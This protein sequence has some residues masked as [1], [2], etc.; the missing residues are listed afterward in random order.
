LRYEVYPRAGELITVGVFYKYFKNPIELYFNQ[1]GAGSSSTFN[2]INADKAR[3]YGAEFELR[4]KLDF[5]E[6]LQNFTLQTNVSYIFNRVERD[7]FQLKRPMQGQS[8]Y[9]FNASLQY[10]IPEIGLN[11]T[12]LYNQIGDRILY[13]GGNDY[14]PVWEATR[15]V[16]DLQI[17]K[18]LLKNSGELKF[19]AT[20]ILN[21]TANY[22][23][24]LNGNS[25]YDKADDALGHPSQVRKQF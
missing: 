24:D 4:K 12:L 6:A 22:Y 9:V 19:N 17:A 1:S 7:S 18:K 21:Q 20:D 16:F 10:D 23:H 5:A 15:P 3:G 13:V 25:K 11:T 2:F 14:P 8:P